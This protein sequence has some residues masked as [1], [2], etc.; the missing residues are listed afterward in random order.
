MHPF[1]LRSQDDPPIVKTHD[2]LT[3][4]PHTLARSNQ[5]EKKEASKTYL[6]E[7]G[8]SLLFGSLIIID[9]SYRVE[10][11]CAIYDVGMSS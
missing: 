2:N 9:L 7:P 11:R 4:Q 6:F 10:K 3:R 1:I 5:R 8:R